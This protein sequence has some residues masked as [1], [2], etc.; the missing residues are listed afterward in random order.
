MQELGQTNPQYL[1]IIARGP[2]IINQLGT[3]PNYE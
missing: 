3:G 1:C 2:V